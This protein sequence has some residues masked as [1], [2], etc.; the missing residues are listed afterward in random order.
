MTET[1]FRIN[2]SRL[3]EYYQYI[4]ERLKYICAQLLVDEEKGWFSRINSIESDPFGMLITKIQ[5]IQAQKQISVLSQKEIDALNEMRITR[6]YW[7]H[8]CFGG[9]WNSIIFK[10][11]ELKNPEYGRKVLADLSEAIEWDRKLAEICGSAS[12]EKEAVK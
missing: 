2:Y 12:E 5:S 3:I 6:N 11:G 7:V 1:D 10:K 8:Q 4:E 9:L